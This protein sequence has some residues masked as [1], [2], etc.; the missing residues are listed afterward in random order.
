MYPVQGSE[1]EEY[2]KKQLV[3]HFLVEVEKCAHPLET[4]TKNQLYKDTSH[5][6]QENPTY[7]VA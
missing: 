3:T 5:K 2:G 1:L 4:I 6:W 7:A